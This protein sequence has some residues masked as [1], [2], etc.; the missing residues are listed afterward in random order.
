MTEGARRANVELKAR[1][2]DHDRAVAI[3]ERLGATF[4]H[5]EEQ[6]DHYFSLGSY[7]M[8][9]RESSL[10]RHWLI[11]YSRPNA[12]G[13]RKSS[14]RLL[15]VPDPSAKR[16]ILSQAMG[17]KAVVRKERS[18]WMWG[19]VRIHLDRVEGLGRFLEFEAVLTDG[20]TEAAGEVDVGRLS[21]EFGINEE[22]MISGSYSDLPAVDHAGA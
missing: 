2:S 22:D 15:P 11:W 8:K 14:Y 3:C 6:V 20:Y 10:G 1:Y 9:L 4:V 18:L 7:R 5:T 17:V 21:R 12:A 19:P 16:K 13:P